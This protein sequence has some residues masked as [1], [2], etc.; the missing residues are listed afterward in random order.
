MSPPSLM[1][2]MREMIFRS[3]INIMEMYRL[4]RAMSFEDKVEMLAMLR[5][6][7]IDQAT[8]VAQ[9]LEKYKN[10]RQMTGRVRGWFLNLYPHKYME[11]LETDHLLKYRGV[12]PVLYNEITRLLRTIRNEEEMYGMIFEEFMSK[13]EAD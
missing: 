10:S 9:W 12:G 3:K 8:P 4:Y 7:G 1:M 2:K 13:Q 11:E 6:N 5:R